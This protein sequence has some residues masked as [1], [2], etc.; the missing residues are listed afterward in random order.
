MARTTNTNANTGSHIADFKI[1]GI[2]TDVYEGK[3]NNYLTI[4]VDGD[5]VNPKTNE[6]YY[7]SIRV[8]AAKDIELYD[9]GTTVEI[10]GIISSYYDK[11]VQR[12]SIILTA[13]CIK[14]VSN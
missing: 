12:T 6:P 2:L 3:K 11:D 14:P 8:T 4:K 5:N 1:V 7:S 9:D 10:G 13:G